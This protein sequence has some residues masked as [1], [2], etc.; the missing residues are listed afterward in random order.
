MSAEST[1]ETIL[2]VDLLSFE[3]GTASERAA[4]VDGVMSSLQ[5]GFVYTAHLSLIHI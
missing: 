1:A 5:S 3:D 2:D 4:V